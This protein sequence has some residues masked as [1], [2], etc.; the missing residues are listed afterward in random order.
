MKF[1]VSTMIALAAS[2][3]VVKTDRRVPPRHPVNRLARLNLFCDS[4]FTQTGWIK[5]S[6]TRGLIKKCNG[7]SAT[8][9]KKVEKGETGETCFFYDPDMPNGGP[10]TNNPPSPPHDADYH[11]NWDSGMLEWQ[12]RKRRSPEDQPGIPAS[13]WFK[14][15]FVAEDGVEM[16]QTFDSSAANYISAEWLDPEAVA[17]AEAEICMDDC[18]ENGD[19]N[20]ETECAVIERARGDKKIAGLK[21]RGP[22]KATRS[23]VTGFRKWGERY[24]ANCHGHRRG[25]HM[26]RRT[27]FITAVSHRFFNHCDHTE[28]SPEGAKNFKWGKKNTRTDWAGK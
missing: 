16:V 27:K 9:Q 26:N 19:S 20:C 18:G 28:C 22:W 14:N 6:R 15:P 11:K 13:S 21:K 17:Q 7:W 24:L 4:L 23:I 12:S 10:D 2:E 3:P 8:M 5:D 1:S 25:T